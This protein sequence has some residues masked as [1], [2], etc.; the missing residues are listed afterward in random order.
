MQISAATLL[1]I[2]DDL[3]TIEQNMLLNRV[4]NVGCGSSL[5]LALCGAASE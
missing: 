5:F 4:K 3:K 1:E 2:D